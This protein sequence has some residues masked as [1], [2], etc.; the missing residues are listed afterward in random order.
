MQKS[1]TY[2]SKRALCTSGKEPYVY[3]ARSPVHYGK[4]PVCVKCVQCMCEV[5]CATPRMA[6][7]NYYTAEEPCIQNKHKYAQIFEN[8]PIYIMNRAVCVILRAH[9]H[10]HTHIRTHTRTHRRTHSDAHA[11]THNHKYAH[12]IARTNTHTLSLSLSL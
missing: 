1:P 6:S 2:I 4:S 8:S 11:H 12:T 9:S 7:Y 10:T 3:D 5:R